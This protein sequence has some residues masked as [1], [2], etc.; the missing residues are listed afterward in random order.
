MNKKKQMD[1]WVQW[2]QQKFEKW[3]QKRIARAESRELFN[4]RVRMITT[5][6]SILCLVAIMIVGIPWLIELYRNYPTLW[7]TAMAPFKNHA[8]E[9]GMVIGSIIVLVIILFSLV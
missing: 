4:F 6:V 3:N 5:G 9:F 1:E 7:P 2:Q 8:A